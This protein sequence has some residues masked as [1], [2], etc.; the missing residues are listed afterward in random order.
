MSRLTPAERMEIIRKYYKNS[1]SIVNTLREFRR[2]VGRH[3]GFSAQTIRRTV[4][5]FEHEFTLLDLKPTSRRRLVRSEETIAAVA[6]SIKEDPDKSIRCLS[7]E[8]GIGRESVRRILRLDLGQHPYKIMM[9]QELELNDHRDRRE[10]VHWALNM[11]TESPEFGEQIIFS[12]K[13]QFWLSG[14]VNTDS[15]CYWSELNPQVL[16]QASIATQGVAVWCGLWNGGI[17]G[18]Y[19]FRNHQGYI[20]S[21]DGPQYRAMLTDFLG[22]ELDSMDT[23]KMWFQHDGAASDETLEILKQKFGDSVISQ[24]ANINWPPRSCDLT[25]IDYFLWAYVKSLAYSNKPTTLE[26][27]EANIRD[28]IAGITPQILNRVIQNWAVRLKHCQRSR[29]G[30]LHDVLFHP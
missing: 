11:L 23:A 25:P 20:A 7:A 22:P 29:G 3:H 27:L 2:E 15:C 9:T 12:G 13:A 4:D 6:T 1:G 5:K 18:P 14:Y 26:E 10:F 28:S 19:F 8:L 17:I 16:D 30:H 21:V 24:R